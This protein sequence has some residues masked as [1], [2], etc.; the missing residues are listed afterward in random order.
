MQRGDVAVEMCYFVGSSGRTST[1]VLRDKKT[2]AKLAD[3]HGSDRGLYPLT[4]R[5]T[6]SAPN[7]YPSYEVVTVDG[8]TEVVE[9]RRMEPVF[10]ISDDPALHHALGVDDAIAPARGKSR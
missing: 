1:F 8:I 6:E 2:R 5:N 9:H 7:E 10:Y 3:V 4:A